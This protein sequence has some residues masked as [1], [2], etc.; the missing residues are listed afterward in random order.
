M[1]QQ[2]LMFIEMILRFLIPH[3]LTML[4]ALRNR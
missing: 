1:A 4:E 3:M 2:F